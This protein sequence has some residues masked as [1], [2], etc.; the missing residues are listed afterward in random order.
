MEAGDKTQGRCISATRVP[1][2]RLFCFPSD[3][4]GVVRKLTSKQLQRLQGIAAASLEL[5]KSDRPDLGIAPEDLIVACNV[6]LGYDALEDSKT[7]TKTS[8]ARSL[9]RTAGAA[10]KPGN[11]DSFAGR[12]RAAVVNHQRW[13][14]DK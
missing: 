8:V 4:A 9:R 13:P 5:S 3:D 2:T 12:R 7:K 1:K 6:V 11:V 10:T 14:K